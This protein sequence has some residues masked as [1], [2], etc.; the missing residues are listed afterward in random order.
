MAM[1]RFRRSLRDRV[2]LRGWLN[3]LST[4]TTEKARELG[5]RTV[6]VTVL[7]FELRKG[8]GVAI[9][10]QTWR[11]TD[12][13]TRKGVSLHQPSRMTAWVRPQIGP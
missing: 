13:P 9:F 7:K 1:H 8:T 5:Q 2:V 12:F 11:D 4:T 10:K 3:F 6:G